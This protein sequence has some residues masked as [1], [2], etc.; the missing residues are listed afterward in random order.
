MRTTTQSPRTRATQ[1]GHVK[2]K[3]VHEVADEVMCIP[4]TSV[5]QGRIGRSRG[6][7]LESKQVCLKPLGGP[8]EVQAWNLLSHVSC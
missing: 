3:H 2:R 5:L 8:F 7:E 1:G 4:P 6:I